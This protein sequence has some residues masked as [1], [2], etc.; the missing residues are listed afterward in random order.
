[1]P[2]FRADVLRR[3]GAWDPF[4]VTEDADLGIRLSRLGYRVAVMGSVT[5]EEATADLES[6]FAQRTRWLKGWLQTWLV[7]M[8]E[9]VRLWHELGAS[10]FWAFQALFGGV[11]VSGLVHPVF[12]AYAPLALA[13]GLATQGLA[14]I[15]GI[16]LAALNG[17][18]LVA[19]YGVAVAAGIV[20]AR[21][22]GH[23]DQW[24][25]AL[26]MPVYWLLVSLAAH[27]ALWQ[28]LRRPFY[29]AKTAHG[30]SALAPASPANPR[31][32]RASLR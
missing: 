10:G 31:A 21:R 14:G 30:H 11:I 5:H 26:T 3:V 29:W 27:A 4:N 19:G 22:R 6:W 15:A 20:A 32:G 9:P 23:V 28:L 24:R 12:I 18:V 25:Y 13:T 17:F 8:R 1:M 7:H 16:A 2:H